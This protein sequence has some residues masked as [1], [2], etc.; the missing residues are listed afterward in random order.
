MNKKFAA[1]DKIELPS[2]KKY[3][4]QCPC[5]PVAEKNFP[6]QLLL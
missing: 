5:L 6:V 1:R 2:S 3:S 4:L